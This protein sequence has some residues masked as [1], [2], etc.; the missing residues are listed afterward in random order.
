MDVFGLRF[1]GCRMEVQLHCGAGRIKDYRLISSPV[2]GLFDSFRLMDKNR[3]LATLQYFD[4]LRNQL[5]RLVFQ[6]EL[7]IAEADHG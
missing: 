1:C 3:K 6:Q 2:S 7:A 5:S 4:P